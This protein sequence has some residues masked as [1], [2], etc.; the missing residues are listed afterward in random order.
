MLASTVF[1]PV[2][3]FG[4]NANPSTSAPRKR[5]ATA[6]AQSSSFRKVRHNP[7]IGFASTL[8]RNS[9]CT[10]CTGIGTAPKEPWFKWAREVSSDHNALTFGQSGP[11][12]G[13]SSDVFRVR[14]AFDA[15]LLGEDSSRIFPHTRISIS[16]LYLFLS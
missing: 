8:R 3:A 15:F 1:T 11:H 5:D 9:S 13:F 10:A 4:T 6:L 2:V 7:R 16:F 14:S 12:S